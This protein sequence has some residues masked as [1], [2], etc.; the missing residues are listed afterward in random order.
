MT[1]RF[2]EGEF[3][4]L[5]C[6]LYALIPRYTLFIKGIALNYRAVS[7]AVMSF[8]EAAPGARLNDAWSAE[9]QK[10]FARRGKKDDKSFNL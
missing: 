6:D 8:R 10:D 2:W 9:I 5:P 7:Q 4:R 1:S 3:C